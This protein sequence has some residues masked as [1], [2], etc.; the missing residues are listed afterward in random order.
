MKIFLLGVKYQNC[1][2]SL[3]SYRFL[4]WYNSVE[5][6]PVKVHFYSKLNNFRKIC[7]FDMICEKK[8]TFISS[9]HWSMICL[10]ISC[11]LLFHFKSLI[12]TPLWVSQKKLFHFVL[13]DDCT[14]LSSP[15]AFG[16]CLTVQYFTSYQINFVQSVMSLLN[17]YTNLQQA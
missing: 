15:D 1:E 13:R 3:I 11:I 10:S 16:C 14:N 5:E 2:V 4:S 9:F 12:G 8:R 7:L 17:V 6:T